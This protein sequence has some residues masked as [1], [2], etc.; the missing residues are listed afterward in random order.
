MTTGS[1]S[2]GQVFSLL[3]RGN[4]N[5]YVLKVQRFQNESQVHVF[6]N[7]QSVGFTPGI[8]EVGVR[9][10]AMTYVNNNVLSKLGMNGAKY[11]GGVLLMEHFVKG[12]TDVLAM[13]LRNYLMTYF[14]NTCPPDNHITETFMMIIYKF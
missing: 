13:S 1:G 14:R 5:K 9:A 4:P 2:Y 7:E 11:G 8:S 3:H 6:L 12:K 10:L